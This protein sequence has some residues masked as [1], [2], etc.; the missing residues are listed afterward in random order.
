MKAGL[1]NFLHRT[2]WWSLFLAAFGIVVALVVF[3]VPYQ[4]FGLENRAFTPAKA[5]PVGY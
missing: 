3:A 5:R 2:P 4:I 1:S